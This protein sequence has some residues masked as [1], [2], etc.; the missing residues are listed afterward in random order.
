[1]DQIHQRSR[2]KQITSKTYACCVIFNLFTWLGRILYHSE[3][4]NLL[5][6]MDEQ[7]CGINDSTDNS[8]VKSLQDSAKGLSAKPVRDCQ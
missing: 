1:M 6:Q 8:F 3:F 2:I 7:L 5:D 4:Y